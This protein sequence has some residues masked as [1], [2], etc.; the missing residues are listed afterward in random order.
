MDYQALATTL[1]TQRRHFYAGLKALDP[2]CLAQPSPN[3]AFW[4]NLYNVL[5]LDAVLTFQVTRSVIGLSQGLLR[6][7]EKAAYVIGNQRLSAND[8]EHGVLRQNRGHFLSRRVQFADDD[9]RRAWVMHPMDPRIHFA[10]HCASRSCPPI[11]VYECT[12][13]SDQLDLATRAF[14]QAETHVDPVRR[15]LEVSTLFKWYRVDFADTGGVVPFALSYLDATD[16]RRL[17]LQDHRT[18]VRI[19]YRKYN[20]DLNA[21]SPGAY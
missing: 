4:I 19:R 15:T 12:H 13:L 10:L 17:W 6:F 7:F 9:P 2:D 14:V 16:P 18:D 5:I 20:W 8:I 21:A 11:R 1:P 3:L